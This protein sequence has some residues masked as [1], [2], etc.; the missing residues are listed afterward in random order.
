MKH[1]KRF[2][3]ILICL[4]LITLSL[5]YQATSAKALRSVPFIFLSK[6]TITA[7]IG[8]VIPLITVASTSKSP[9]WKSSNSTIASVKSGTITAKKAGTATITAKIQG[10]QATCHITVKKT[11][12]TIS[13]TRITLEHGDSYKLSA[14]TS[15]GST[16][17]WKSSKKSV[18][19]IDQNGSLTACKPGETTIT[20][21][22]DGSSVTCV[23]TVKSPTI[24]LSKTM[25]VLY[26]GQTETLSAEVSSH[27]SPKWK[28]N[29]KSVAIVSEDGTITA[30]KNGNAT[31]TATVDGV[32]KSCQVV[33]LK[34]NITL[35]S[36]ELFLKK[37]DHATLSA[38]VSSGNI[39]VWSSSNSDIVS[40]QSNGEIT[41]LQA[42][43]AYVYAAEDGMK[44]RC[45]IHVTE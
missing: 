1:F 28:T 17:N 25:I 7:E 10:A 8:D 26:R 19:I 5:P 22:A 39:P 9:T 36:Y 12:I 42:G 32:S 44:V 33:V 34:P 16:V 13:K 31:I 41:A 20:A 35:N 24:Q 14:V 6:S 27:V 2:F 40:V 18:A 11:S 3:S 43:T 30:V 23:V 38:T 4:T 15:N 45:K 21:G 29:K 37:G